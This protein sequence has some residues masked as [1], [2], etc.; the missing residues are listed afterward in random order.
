MCVC[1]CVRVCVQEFTEPSLK[2]K[3]LILFSIEV[4]RDWLIFNQ[5]LDTQ[6]ET[7]QIISYRIEEISGQIFFPWKNRMLM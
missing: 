6:K 1:V 4:E 7:P 3:W 2:E 5:S